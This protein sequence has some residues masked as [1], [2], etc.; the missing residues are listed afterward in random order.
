MP[1]PKPST[2]PLQDLYDLIE[3]G[4][5]QKDVAYQGK[6]FTFRSLREEDFAW[7]DQFVNTTNA[8]AMMSSS[9]S[10][11]LAIA[12]LAIDGIGVE[13]IDDLQE[14]PED[15]PQVLRESAQT[16]RNLLIAYNLHR[17]VYSQMPRDYLVGLHEAYVDQVEVPSRVVKDKDVKKS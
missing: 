17:K 8:F 15:Y 10:P 3:K 7:R 12:T 1:M 4:H 14:F 9:R 16:D 5:I 13:Q 11:T 6:T 2:N